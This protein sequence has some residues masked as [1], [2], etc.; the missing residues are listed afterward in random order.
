MAA[1]SRV[2]RV[3]EI[4]NNLPKYVNY[5]SKTLEAMLKSVSVTSD[6]GT[7]VLT[8]SEVSGAFA[9]GDKKL[10]G[11]AQPIAEGEVVALSTGAK[12]ATSLIPDL[13]STYLTAS[14]KGAA[15]GVAELDTGGR[16]PSAQLPSYVDDVIEAA[17]FAALPTVGAYGSYTGTPTGGTTEV[18]ITADTRGTAGNAT[19]VADSVKTITVLISDWNT[20][21]PTN[22]LTLTAGDGSQVPTADIVLAGGVNIL[23]EAGK[24]YVTLDDN[25]TYRYSGTAY[26]EVSASLALGETSATA[27]RG[28]RGKTAYDHAGL[29]T[30]NPHAVTKSEVSLGNVDNVQQMPLSYLDTD[31]TLAANSD[32]KV[33]SQAAVK[34]YVSAQVGSSDSASFTNKEGGSVAHTARQLT[35]LDT[36]AS[37]MKKVIAT[38]ATLA[39][40]VLLAMVKDASIADNAAGQYYLPRRGTIVGGFTGL[41]VGPL[42]VSRSSAGGTAQ[43]LTGFTTNDHVILV[44]W[45][46][47]ATEVLWVGEYQYQIG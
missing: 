4:V 17:N 26:V 33:P 28:D 35:F 12:I 2:L 15:S 42:F 3:I 1:T 44:G 47:S 32:T 14:Q 5:D 24:I 6:N 18:T 30:G 36:A 31:P 20:A 39:P 41:T 40:T 11:V 16:V 34:S 23:A 27:Y 9:F 38:E 21:H 22:T 13:S 10:T 19:L 29:V 46:I 25:K 7:T 37:G 43:D 45:A 8:I